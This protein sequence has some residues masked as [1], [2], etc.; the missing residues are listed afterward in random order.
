MRVR[1]ARNAGIRNVLNR[2]GATRVL[3]RRDV[4]VVWDTVSW[5]VHDVLE[6]RT[7]ADSIINLGFLSNKWTEM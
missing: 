4:V 1:Y 5:V 3:R 7:E 6:D 2:V